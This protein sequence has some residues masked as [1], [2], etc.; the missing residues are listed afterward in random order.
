M[1]GG[2]GGQMSFE[3]YFVDIYLLQTAFCVLYTYYCQH[4]DTHTHTHTQESFITIDTRSSTLQLDRG[5]FW[6]TGHEKGQD[7]WSVGFS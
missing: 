3:W 5:Y 1:W 7:T 6:R 2:G 4:A